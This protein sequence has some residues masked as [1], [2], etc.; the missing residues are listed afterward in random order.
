VLQEELERC[1]LRQLAG[2]SRNSFRLVSFF[3]RRSKKNPEMGRLYHD[4]HHYI[5]ESYFLIR[6][7]LNDE[8]LPNIHMLSVQCLSRA[9][10]NENP[11]LLMAASTLL[12][13]FQPFVVSAVHTGMM[14]ASHP[15]N[16][17]DCSV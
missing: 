3:Q 7:P 13:P 5:G 16:L 11:G 14:E 12:L 1:H 4:C 8:K 10:R 9:V 17:A 15:N 6:L 2:W